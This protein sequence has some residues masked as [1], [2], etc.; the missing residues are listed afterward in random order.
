MK[1]SFDQPND[2][3]TISTLGGFNPL[4]EG[5]IVSINGKEWKVKRGGYG[6]KLVNTESE[7]HPQIFDIE[8]MSSLI[9]AIKIEAG[10]A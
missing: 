1:T 5:D 2:T 3:K 7:T 10:E 8:A 9:R 4:M 6:W